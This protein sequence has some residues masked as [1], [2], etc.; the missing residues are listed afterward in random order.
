MREQNALSTGQKG[1]MHVLFGRPNGTVRLSSD[2][3]FEMSPAPV[4]AN[5]NGSAFPAKAATHKHEHSV[6]F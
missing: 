4:K 1:N 2:I 5:L 3:I 6:F